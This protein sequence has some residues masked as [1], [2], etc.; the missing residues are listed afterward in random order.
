MT[1]DVDI[2]DW[3]HGFDTPFSPRTT[4]GQTAEG[5]YP[6][7]VAIDGREYVIDLA[8]YARRTLPQLRTQSDT[9]QEPG[10]QSL[11]IEGMWKRTGTAAYLGA[12]QRFYDDVDSDRHRFWQS[13]GIDGWTRRQIRLLNDTS[14][15]R[16]TANTGLRLLKV[17]GYMVLVDGNQCYAS[18]DPLTP[19]TWV[20]QDSPGVPV[21]SIATNGSLVFEACGSGG[22]R[23]FVPGTPG[24]SSFVAGGVFAATLVVYANGWLVGT[25]ANLIDSFDSAGAPTTVGRHRNPGFTWNTGT[26]APNA[27]YLAGNAGD[28]AE[29][30]RITVDPNT[31]A[32]LLPP[33]FAGELPA[34]ETIN[35]ISYYVGTMLLGTSRGLRVA[36]I[37]SDGGLS[38]G[39]VIEEPSGQGVACFDGRGQYAWFGWVNDYDSDHRGLARA[40][41]AHYTEA[42]V[43][44]YAAD[45]SASPATA[46][47][48]TSA[49]AS[50][51][52][53]GKDYRLFAIDGDGIF[54]EADELVPEGAIDVGWLGQ[55]SP[56][57]KS[58][59]SI[60]V[61]HDALE[62]T[63]TMTVA[64]EEGQS[65]EAVSQIQASFGSGS[66]DRNLIGELLDLTLTLDRSALDPTAGPVVHRWTLSV[67]PA[68]PAVEEII[69]PI[70]MLNTVNDSQTDKK[71]LY[72]TYEE[73]FRLKEIENSRRVVT[74]R[75]G[76]ISYDVTIRSV[77]IPGIDYLGRADRKW[78]KDRRFFETTMNVRMITLDGVPP[79]V[80]GI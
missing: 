23:K 20:I 37:N 57:Q 8:R 24:G 6:A 14:R 74:Y 36:T 3:R 7:P 45:L 61:S 22:I 32:S 1:V 30:H 19:G 34:G 17:G 56:E 33:V 10:E 12:G 48:I 62:G 44:A 15:V 63:V 70:I 26:S 31:G 18:S 39:P 4:T 5:A 58:M 9:S 49:V 72:D 46:S 77:E 40:D 2:F 50:W 67:I 16:A 51:R 65:E 41:L 60:S 29:I 38:I 76:Q 13:R 59:G 78:A 52:A 79:R 54:A 64:N 73:F 11:E 75:E 43:P 42:G 66:V 28:R 80:G 69:I 47:G 25:K 21:L 53:G 71:F 68:P 35:C 27:I 55:A